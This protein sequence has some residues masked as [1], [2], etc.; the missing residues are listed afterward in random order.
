[1]RVAFLLVAIAA[2]GCAT[3]SKTYGPDGRVAHS[4]GCSGAALSWGLCL[5][6]A[7]E[8]CGASGYDVLS[9]SGEMGHIAT[10][11]ATRQNASFFA[12]STAS[13]SMLIACKAS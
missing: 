7:G 13:R 10:G 9:S 11:T 12:G 6:K 5:E 8:I 2:A 1:M 3:S 4:I